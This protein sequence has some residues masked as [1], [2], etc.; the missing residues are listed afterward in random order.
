MAT[1]EGVL[2][3]GASGFVGSAVARALAV[4][5]HRVRVLVRESS[6]RRNLAGLDAEVVVGD[7]LE[8]ESM[9][10]A[11]HGVRYVFHVAADYRLWAR[12]PAQIE[13]NNL[14]GTRVVMQAALDAQVERVVYT[15]SV[16][17]LRVDESTSAATED[18]PLAAAE[19]I[20]AYKRSKV[21]AEELVLK[22]TVDNG[23]PAVIVNPSTP[24]G[25]R[26]VRP[27]PTGR[28][29]VEAACGRMPA[30]VDTGLNVV[31]VDDVAA[32]HVLALERGRVG[33]RYILGGDNLS[34]QALLA[35]IASLT[36]RRAPRVRLPV[37]PLYPLARAA[38]ALAHFT[39]REPFL[40]RDGLK[41]S[42]NRMHFSSAK[43]HSELGY[44]PRPHGEGLREAIDWFSR[45]GYLK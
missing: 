25:A 21:L 43:A 39:G 10:R 45:E 36:G 7:M 33:Q 42:R 32:G 18:A 20:G 23:L 29:I 3:T 15:S 4:R 1:G 2:V 19:A 5:G 24:I 16:A 41:M 12:E 11:L 22:M 38:E 17:T 30:F 37:A 34:L 26:D 40:T 14:E 8:R 13:R 6:S 28:I 35:E 44:C 27:T 31:G 9:L